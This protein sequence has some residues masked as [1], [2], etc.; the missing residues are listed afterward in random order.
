MVVRR[1]IRNLFG[2]GARCDARPRLRELQLRLLD[3][4]RYRRHLRDAP[5]R[6]HRGVRR[7]GRGR[8]GDGYLRPH[9]GVRSHLRLRQRS[10]HARPEGDVGPR[11]RPAKPEV[12]RARPR[13]ASGTIGSRRPMSLSGGPAILR[14]PRLHDDDAVRVGDPIG[15]VDAHEA[16]GADAVD[17]EAA[18]EQRL[19]RESLGRQPRVVEG[20]LAADVLL[21]SGG[22]PAQRQ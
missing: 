22:I 8:R 4:R 13:G 21:R 1:R 5:R 15:P 7:G 6:A 17:L 19:L 14:R 9:R 11:P 12:E 3:V 16:L 2:L 20:Q 10:P 18:G